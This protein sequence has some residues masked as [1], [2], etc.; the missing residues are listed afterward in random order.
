MLLKVISS[1]SLRFTPVVTPLV[2]RE[3]SHTIYITLTLLAILSFRILV[4]QSQT[5]SHFTVTLSPHFVQVLTD[6]SIVPESYCEA[7]KRLHLPLA[8]FTPFTPHSLRIFVPHL[9]IRS[10]TLKI[11]S[12]ALI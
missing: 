7:L 10:H 4:Y 12:L 5:R 3:P 2:T 6:H 1:L 11:L 9:Q 8:I